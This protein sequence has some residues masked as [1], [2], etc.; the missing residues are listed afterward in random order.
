MV[1]W[2][3]LRLEEKNNLIELLCMSLLL[4]DGH[5]PTSALEV[6]KYDLQAQHGKDYFSVAGDRHYCPDL[7]WCYRPVYFY[8]LIIISGRMLCCA[9][10]GYP[11]D[12]L[13]VNVT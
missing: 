9:T 3:K 11:T 5:S 4:Q 6:L 12:M 2:L 13:M 1:W 10:C 8:G 7:Q